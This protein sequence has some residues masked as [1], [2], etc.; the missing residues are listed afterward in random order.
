MRFFAS[1]ASDFPIL[2]S[3]DVIPFE[4]R[5]HRWTPEALTCLTRIHTA[6]GKI[7]GARVL[8][9][10]ADQLRA[11]ARVGTVHYSNLIEGNELPLIEAERAA[12]GH[13]APD[14]RA[15]IELINYVSALDLIDRRLANGSLE[16]TPGFLKEL[17]K[18]VTDG[19]GREDDPHFKPHHEGEWRD[20]EAFVV[21]RMTQ[22]VMHQGPPQAEVEP[23]MRGMFAWLDAMLERQSEPSFV[24]AGVLHYGVTDV[25]P[26]ADGNGRVARL[27]QVALLM[28]ADVLPGRMFSFE[29]YY[30]EDRN[31]Y[32]SA[33]RS[34]RERTLNMEAWLH[35]LLAG[36]AEE[37]ERVATTIEDLSA[38]T[39][40][41]T[42]QLQL[43]SSQQRA[44]TR[45][46]IE[47]RR[48]FNRAEYE[49]VAA[50]GRTTAITDLQALVSHGVLQMRG[51]GP[52]TR[53]ALPGPAHERQAQ[54]PGRPRRWTDGRIERELSVYL[55]GRS[56]WPTPAEFRAAGQGGLYAAASRSGGI[57]RWR[58]LLGR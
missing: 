28:N 24:L 36:L 51:Q 1:K 54:G 56:G 34:V 52:S 17:H 29:R 7:K 2:N 3:T 31:A 42:A 19:L 18:A 41:G 25:H 44:L 4:P 30:A 40:G 8:P 49:R 9:A 57:A 14:T 46:R 37:Y 50:V 20:G 33:L 47:G 55:D 32:Y 6:L 5:F 26:F 23:K 21:D 12:R 53:Y 39:S 13:L 15:K 45:L 35:Y 58:R 22:Q 16:L 27:L 48:E 43:T 38:L 10:V 11:S